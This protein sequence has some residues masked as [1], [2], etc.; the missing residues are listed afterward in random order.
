MTAVPALAM[1]FLPEQL[2]Q[3][4]PLVV[5]V[6]PTAVGK[7]RVAVELAKRLETEIVTADSRQIYSGMDV[8]T[9]KPPVE[10][11]QGIPH[12]LIDLV[13]PDQSFNTGLFRQHALEAIGELYGCGKLPLVV[14]GTGLYV[15]T[16]LQGLCEAPS[17]D[18]TVRTQLC[19]DSRR[20]GPDR[21]YARLVEV[22]PITASKLHPRD[23]S[24]VIRALEVHQL[25]G[26][27][28]SEF[29]RRHGFADRPFTALV[30]GLDRDRAALYRRIEERIDWQLANGLLEE[31]RRLL[32]QGYRRES[33]ALKGLGY[34]Q[35]AEH[36][37]GEYDWPEMVRLFKRDTR[38]FAKRQMTWFR[39]QQGITW[40]MLSERETTGMI[41][42]R[43]AE[44]V[45]TFLTA[46]GLAGNG[47][48][49][50]SER[51]E[52]IAPS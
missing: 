37:A 10:S 17:A 43:V 32:D 22:D 31:T 14:G 26:Q 5:L 18:P 50:A 44:L 34:R 42:D 29:Q 48:D 3:L 45:E 35:I 19:E 46:H 12:R 30:I 24:K 36:L 6:G 49:H 11:R 51:T 23:T 33:S 39:K 41:V 8:G 47:T 4:K 25:S 16:L 7:S 27:P 52:E 2:R 40:V 21:L 28:M 1:R 9:D 15:R 38:H 13:N 20:Q